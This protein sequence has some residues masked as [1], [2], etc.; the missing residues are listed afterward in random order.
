MIDMTDKVC[1]N[2]GE[3]RYTLWRGRQAPGPLCVLLPEEEDTE[4][5]LME[6]AE[7]IL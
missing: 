2:K 4:K 5:S 6:K 7:L 3:L 1:G